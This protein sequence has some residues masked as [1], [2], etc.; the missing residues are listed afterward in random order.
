MGQRRDELADLGRDL[1]RMAR[2]LAQLMEGQRRL[3]HDVS[4]ELRS[5]L[6]RLNAII[7]LARQQPDSLNDCL[8]RLEYES[9]CMDRLLSEL[10]I[11]FLIH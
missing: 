5:P 11:P 8:S 10:L 4:H 1:D 3:L 2:H 6:A 9:I 7:G